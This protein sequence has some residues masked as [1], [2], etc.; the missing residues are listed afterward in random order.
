MRFKNWINKA[1]AEDFISGYL[2]DSF[3]RTL[4]DDLF[5]ES[6]HM[7]QAGYKDFVSDRSKYAGK[8]VWYKPGEPL[9]MHTG[10]LEQKP[11]GYTATE[12][13]PPVPN[14]PVDPRAP[15][16]P[17]RMTQPPQ[18]AP[19]V[20]SEPHPQPTAGEGVR[21]WYLAKALEEHEGFKKNDKLA[22]SKLADGDWEVATVMGQRIYIPKE[23]IAKIFQSM[24]RDGKPWKG[25]TPAELLGEPV[26]GRMPPWR[27]RQHQESIEKSFLGEHGVPETKKPNMVI[28]ALA[29]TGKTTM[30]KHLASYKPKNEKWLYLVFN[31]KNQNE[32]VKEFPK[33]GIE[34]KTTHS[35]MGDVLKMNGKSEGGI[36]PKTDLPAKGEKPRMGDIVEQ[37]DGNWFK[38]LAKDLDIK[39]TLVYPIKIRSKKLA[40]MAKHYSIHP[41]DPKIDSKLNDLVKKYR[42]IDPK[43]V[44]GQKENQNP[45]GR[46]YTDEIVHLAKLLLQ[47]SMPGKAPEGRASKLRDHDDTLWWPAILA[48]QMRWP[49]YDV[50][51]ADEIQDLNKNQITM[52]EMLQKVGARIIAVGD[53][54]QAIYRFRGAD[55]GAF[56]NLTEM[57]KGTPQGADVHEL[58]E[59]FRCGKA[60][61]NHVNADTHVNNLVAGL[62]HEGEVTTHKEYADVMSDVEKEWKKNGMALDHQT[63]MISRTNK[64]L[65]LTALNLMRKNIPFVLLGR[66]LANELSDFIGEITG[67]GLR[68]KTMSIPNL[69]NGMHEMIAHHENEFAGTGNSNKAHEIEEMKQTGE[70][71][72]G[73]LDYLQEHDYKDPMSGIPVKNSDDFLQ[74]VKAIFGGLN[75]NDDE[76]DAAKY[77]KMQ[78]DPKKF[79]TLTT[80]HRSKGLEFD[81]VYIVRDDQF[82]HPRAQGEEEMA[83]EDNARYVAYTRAKHKLHILADDEPGGSSDS[84]KKYG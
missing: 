6:R 21:V 22:V 30:L 74:Y 27:M 9:I 20:A 58:P 83:Q 62:D 49:H 10:D 56:S 16:Q 29:G 84:K 59:N 45:A 1:A 73:V 42:E 64:P 14:V 80:A 46:D 8:R 24:K 12:A 60:I 48:K 37:Q 40:T 76:F 36:M 31:S 3:L 66:D 65:M 53:P 52:L 26:Q 41:D 81:R 5:I 78:E 19:E 2:P 69:Q 72:E 28:N 15:K 63:A 25:A 61:I 79:V 38:K 75:Q 51:L 39:S 70:A 77:K 11:P 18:R 13:P 68:K 43:M 82:P 54:N 35:F 44:E 32:A 47:Q 71:L 50:V 57:L 55:S 34:I 7:Y 23:N 17:P 33:N 67:K 4:K